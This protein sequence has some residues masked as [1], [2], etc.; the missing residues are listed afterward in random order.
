MN[1]RMVMVYIVGFII[2]I[3]FGSLLQSINNDP[4]Y[5]KQWKIPF[6]ETCNGVQSCA[7]QVC[8]EG[9]EGRGHC[10]CGGCCFDCVEKERKE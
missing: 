6:D 7:S 4:C 2:V 8:P 3:W 9:Y 1:K 5:G 10:A